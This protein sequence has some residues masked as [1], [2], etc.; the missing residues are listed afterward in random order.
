[1]THGS[2]QR[3]GNTAP[4]AVPFYEPNHPPEDSNETIPETPQPSSAIIAA[5]DH[6]PLAYVDQAQHKKD[7]QIMEVPECNQLITAAKPL[8]WQPLVEESS[9]R[10]KDTNK[11]PVY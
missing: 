1:M 4:F 3:Y 8:Q 7:E 5:Q 9:R 10:V 11:L 2:K 6:V